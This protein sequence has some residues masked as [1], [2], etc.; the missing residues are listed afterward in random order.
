MDNKDDVLL[1]FSQ[2]W[3]FDN[4][5]DVLLVINWDDALLTV[6][7]NWGIIEGQQELRYR[8]WMTKMMNYWLLARTDVLMTVNGYDVLLMVIGDDVLLTVNTN[9]GIDDC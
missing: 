8:W 5:Y 9:W 2:N 3:C 6:N 4:G 7:E 1:M